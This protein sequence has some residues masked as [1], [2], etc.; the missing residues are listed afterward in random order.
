ME[1]SQ[2]TS[3]TPQAVISLPQ[4]RAASQEASTV[5]PNITLTR[6]DSANS[7]DSQGGPPQE[8]TASKEASEAPQQHFF[9][10]R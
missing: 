2:A 3:T 8:S 1:A 7:A 10:E 9:L 5:C 4:D 6:E